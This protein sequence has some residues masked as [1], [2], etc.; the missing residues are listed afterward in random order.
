M[1]GNFFIISICWPFL[2]CWVMISG[3]KL[4]Y[5][6][7]PSNSTHGGPGT[8][9]TGNDFT[10]CSRVLGGCRYN[11]VLAKI[12]YLFWVSVL[13]FK[14]LRCKDMGFGLNKSATW[15]GCSFSLSAFF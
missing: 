12:L 4:V 2:L 11:N 9:S 1:V 5:S 14:G 10:A 7:W 6:G 8:F 3:A 13:C 15:Q